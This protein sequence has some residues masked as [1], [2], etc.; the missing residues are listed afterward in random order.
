[1]VTNDSKQTNIGR[2]CIESQTV[3]PLFQK[4]THILVV[5]KHK[6]HVVDEYIRSV[7]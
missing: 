4:F 7:C 6:A 2:N 3:L 5:N 1:M